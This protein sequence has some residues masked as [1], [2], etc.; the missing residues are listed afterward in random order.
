MPILKK[1][2]SK[3][4]EL[5]MNVGRFMI[6]FPKQCPTLVDLDV[7]WQRFLNECMDDVTERLKKQS[8][9]VEDKINKCPTEEWIEDR[10]RVKASTGDYGS[11]AKDIRDLRIALDPLIEKNLTLRRFID[12]V[13]MFEMNEIKE[14][15]LNQKIDKIAFK[16]K[17]MKDTIDKEI[18]GYVQRISDNEKLCGIINEEM[19]ELKFTVERNAK[20]SRNDASKHTQD[21][22]PLSR[23]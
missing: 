23:R 19:T 15:D 18:A 21:R 5:D 6:E 10:L 14:K 2:F 20:K 16:M 11:L 8:K 9:M 22:V 3:Q 7:Q 4:V 17:E 13:E 12:K 1:V